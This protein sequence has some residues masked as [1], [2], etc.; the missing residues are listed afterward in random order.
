MTKNLFQNNL[1]STPKTCLRG[2]KNNKSRIK[3]EN[4]FDIQYFFLILCADRDG[5]LLQRVF[6]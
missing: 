4:I 3:S 5:E 2:W 6:K 1:F